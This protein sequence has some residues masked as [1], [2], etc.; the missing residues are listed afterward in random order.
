MKTFNELYD[1]MLQSVLDPNSDSNLE[2]IQNSAHKSDFDPEQLDCLLNPKKHPLIIRTDRCTCSKESQSECLKKCAFDALYLTEDGVTVNPDLCMGC[3]EC[4]DGCSSEKLK[5]T[6]DIIPTLQAVRKSK[7]LTYAMIAP[8]FLG[9]FSEKIT[10]GQLRAAMQEVGFDGMV[11]VALFA[12]ILTLKESLEFDHKIQNSE[13]FQ[14]TS[15]CCPMWVGMIR[16]QYHELIGH[17]PG[18]VSPMVACGR[19]IKALHPDALTVFIGP[20]LAKK[21]EAR[22]PDIADAVDYVLTFQ[23]MQNIFEALGIDPVSMPDQKKNHSSKAGIIYAR[24]GGVGEAVKST[25]EAIDPTKTIITKNA[26]GVPACKQ[27]MQEI[28][29]GK[30][31]ANFY[32]GMGCVGGCVG[33][34][35]ALL[36][37]E[38]GAELVNEYGNKAS[39]RNPA[40]NPYVIE[41]LNRI[42]LSS[43]ES[44]INEPNMFDRDIS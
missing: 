43:I 10:P 8:A 29:A 32:E 7:A 18:S 25:L 1:Y 34:P 6:T 31:D 19:V 20:C 11:E 30:R 37:A 9:Q 17:V 14:L 4:I 21:Q 33:G 13:D 26:S 44:L 38:K 39:Y 40:E 28:L 27:M 5:A 3:H 2:S 15:C 12:D 23:E 42:G 35:R 16:K 41:L 22:Q 24:A 36:N